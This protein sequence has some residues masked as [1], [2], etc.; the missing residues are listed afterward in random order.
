MLNTDTHTD[1][2]RHAHEDAIK[3]R[4]TRDAIYAHEANVKARDEEKKLNLAHE[5]DLISKQIETMKLALF[6]LKY[7]CFFPSKIFSDGKYTI[8][9]HGDRLPGDIYEVDLSNAAASDRELD[10]KNLLH[11]FM[12]DTFKCIIIKMRYPIEPGQSSDD[13]LAEF[14]D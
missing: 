14:A 10:L 1:E 8:Y 3:L 12:C 11:R 2:Q 6:R 7:S 9:P 13:I 4:E 5:L